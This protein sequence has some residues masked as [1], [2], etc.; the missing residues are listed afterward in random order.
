MTEPTTNKPTEEEEQDQSLVLVQIMNDGYAAALYISP[1]AEPYPTE[2]QLYLA[3]EKAKVTQGIDDK[4][5]AHLL[6]KKILGKALIFAKGDEPSEG[7]AARLIWHN[8]N[9]EHAT[10]EDIS[11]DYADQGNNLY[12]TAPVSKGDK[13]LS[14]LPPTDGERGIN[15]FGKSV[16]KSGKDLQLPE[17]KGASLSPDGLTLVAD[18]SGVAILQGGELTV[19]DV[20]VI[21]GSVDAQTGDIKVDRSVYIEK[22]V[23]S[24]F[25]VEAVGDIFVGGNIEGADVYSRGGSVVVANG[26]LGQSRAKILAAHDIVAGFIQEATVGAK[27]NVIVD[28][29]IINSAVTAGNHI[30]AIKR[31]GIVRGGSLFAEKRIEIRV[32]GSDG[33]IQTELRVG[34]TRPE[35][36]SRAKFLLKNDQRRNRMELAYV[37]KRLSF[38]NLLKERTGKLTEEKEAQLKELKAKENILLHQY[39]EQSTEEEK[40]AGEEIDETEKKIEVESIR[41]HESVFPEVTLAIGDATM[42]M[43]RERTNVMFYRSGEKLTF[44]PLNQALSHKK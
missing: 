44:G 42:V 1:D 39:R 43:N 9:L 19:R 17:S 30:M 38:L 11:G 3:I 8:S 10:P 13:I 34:Y 24:G 26:I 12:L 18:I 6:K 5:V 41:I 35:N 23:R 25:R 36:V 7:G 2:K 4:V 22:D 31:E 21:K 32:G 14:K 37:Q 15:V 40:L 27:Q 16:S 28:R 33:R 20:Q 29:Y